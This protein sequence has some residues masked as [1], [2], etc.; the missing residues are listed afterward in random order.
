VQDAYQ[1]VAHEHRHN[2]QRFHAR[3]VQKRTGASVDDVEDDGRLGL[4]HAA[5]KAHTELEA[6][7]SPSLL[8]ESDR[9]DGNQLLVGVEE[10]DC[11]RI[12]GQEIP[13]TL[14]E[15]LE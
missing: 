8:V 6:K 3:S 11:R 9:R 13:T 7:P 15:F 1:L 10:R 12:R 5:G 4:G 2:D 14:D